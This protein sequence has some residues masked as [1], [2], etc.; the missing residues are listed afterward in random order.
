MTR[1]CGNTSSSLRQS[2]NDK[3]CGAA[4]SLQVS[5]EPSPSVPSTEPKLCPVIHSRVDPHTAC[6]GMPYACVLRSIGQS[7]PWHHRWQWRSP[8]FLV[9]HK[10][11]QCFTCN[12]VT[13][14]GMMVQA[15]GGGEAQNGTS[16]GFKQACQRTTE[17]SSWQWRSPAIGD[18][19]DDVCM[20]APRSG[21]HEML[22]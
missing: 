7:I 6:H 18:I 14:S 22:L 20:R 13:H 16:M 11:Q 5:N 3:L 4:D 15:A 12:G 10:S 1:V 8:T 9:S 19:G 2:S 17:L 21:Q